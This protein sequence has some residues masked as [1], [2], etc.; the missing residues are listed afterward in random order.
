M[1]SNIVKNEFIS[2]ISHELRT[3]LVPIKG[4]TEMLLNP[5]L[6]GQ[7]NEKQ[8]KAI[9]S[10]YRNVK[11]QESLVEDILD[12]TKL[13]LGQLNLLKKDVI[14]PDFFSNV[15]KDLKFMTEKHVDIVVDIETNMEKSKVYCDEKRIEQVL[16]NLIK[17]S[18]DFVPSKEGKIVLHVEKKEKQ[19]INAHN[20]NKHTY[21]DD[22]SHFLVF[23]VK[24]NGP[25]IPKDKIGN[26]F[27][28]F[29]QIDTSV[30]RSHAGTGLG[31]VICKGIIE[32][33]G[34][35]IWVD[36]NHNNGCSISFSIP[37]IGYNN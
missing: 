9:Q 32:A 11:K 14:I 18:I 29:Y 24:D 20:K 4:Y 12:S 5:K 37:L 1:N 36:K 34:G 3:P 33:H 22:V 16:S 28:R 27:R 25:G 26:L 21:Y 23:T 31:L 2:M 13:D 7:L 15:I 17:N 8:L 30:T 10:I 35:Q 6:L 19:L